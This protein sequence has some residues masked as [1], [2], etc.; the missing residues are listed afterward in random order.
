M[1]CESQ[2]LPYK[3]TLPKNMY[4]TGYQLHGPSG[5]NPQ[6]GAC[7]GS[8]LL[9]TLGSL[10]WSLYFME[11]WIVGD[12][13]ST[14]LYQTYQHE[15][16]LILFILLV[17]NQRSDLLTVKHD[18]KTW[19]PVGFIDREGTERFVCNRGMRWNESPFGGSSRTPN[20][21]PS[22]ATNRCL[23]H[24]GSWSL[25]KF[26]SSIYISPFKLSLAVTLETLPVWSTSSLCF[27]HLFLS[28]MPELPPAAGTEVRCS[29]R[30]STGV[31]ACVLTVA[32]T[33]ESS[34]DMSM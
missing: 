31:V 18:V 1:I 23:F 22:P 29:I 28:R 11:E 8:S 30:K 32:S 6:L 20:L 25:L 7:A 33:T 13:K 5:S 34:S 19:K 24:A 4:G 16:K 3:L 14:C 10:Y 12:H 26:L 15:K 21:Y 27:Q 2:I 9:V 17:N